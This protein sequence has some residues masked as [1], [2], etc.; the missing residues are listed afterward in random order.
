MGEGGMPEEVRGADV[1]GTDGEL[2]RNLAGDRERQ[3]RADVRAA[4]A[5]GRADE[6]A[7]LDRDINDFGYAN[8]VRDRLPDSMLRHISTT[9]VASVLA[10]YAAERGE[11]LD[12]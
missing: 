9:D 7:R 1:E 4:Y 10:A 3:R 12:D 11:H 2:L 8:R 5:A 6:R